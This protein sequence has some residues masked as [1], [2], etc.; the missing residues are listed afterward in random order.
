M[1]WQPIRIFQMGFFA[2]CFGGRSVAVAGPVVV[3]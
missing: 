3:P 2:A 1:S